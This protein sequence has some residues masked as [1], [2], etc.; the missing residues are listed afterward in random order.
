MEKQK[1]RGIS[2]RAKL[3][4]ITIPIVLVMIIS[5][6]I[7]ASNMVLKIS[8]E[9]LQA[10]SLA[11]TGE[12]SL[13]SNQIFGELEIYKNTINEGNFKDDAAI[14]A[15]METTVDKN[16]SYSVGLYMGDDSGIYLDGSGWVPGDDWVL[17]E[18]D[19]YVDGK[20]NAELAFGEP[21]YD[22]MTGQVC[23]SA[24][25]RMDY[26][27]AVRVLA[28]D[29]Y[30]DYVSGLV[31]DIAKEGVVEAFLVTG[32]SRTIIA[33]P[34]KEMMALTL[35]A[36]D[37]DKMY[38]GIS[39]KIQNGTTGL[40]SVQGAAGEYLVCINPV[41][42]TD[43]YLVTYVTEK[44]VL[45]DLYQMEFYMVLI[46]AAVTVLLIFVILRIMNGVVKPVAKV[47]N[48]IDRI[49]EGDFTQNLEVRGNDE[50]A[51]MSNN[52]Q[53]FIVQMRS[54]ISEISGIAEW[55]DTQ[56]AENAEVSDSLMD[57]SEKQAQAMDVLDK[58]VIQLSVAAESVSRQM[59]QLAEVI[60]FAN[61]EGEA[62]EVLMEESVKMSQG[63]KNDME[64]INAGME[65]I[66]IA[67]TSLS[68]QIGKVG[69]ATAQIGEMVGIIMDIAEE[70]NLLSLNASIEAARAGEAG[71]GFAV[72]A[73]QI[74]KLAA[75]SSVA[76]DDIARLTTEI[77]ST[78]EDAVEHMNTSVKEVENSAD[79]VAGARETFEGLYGKVDETSRRVNQ[80]IE[81]VGMVD[82]VAGELEHITESQV[83]ATEQIV[84][85]AKELDAHMKV[86]AEN[87]NSVAESA[88]ELEQESKKLTE[89]MNKF[90]I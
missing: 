17:T 39:D 35:D 68:E 56:S 41:E 54:T 13:W 12:I 4:G 63:G 23:V 59:E 7:L 75:N 61:E 83:Q 45:S 60:R 64:H 33:H 38:A 18:R 27:K 87:S 19:W 48:V 25:V 85:S 88:E 44:A 84:H 74:G 49:A 26:D 55:L 36:E 81:L 51:R 15:Y 76:A 82:T 65:N 57:A 71:K 1:K 62:A 72:V 30:L 90:R 29:V 34:D 86:L 28:T 70:T 47:T 80:M 77:R 14:L 58:M 22:S 79:I 9:Q 66:T 42:H 6:F 16:E 31:A 53:H 40:V 11:Y 8:K 21:Y 67:I 5:F 10:K 73:E 24:S 3:V 52:I 37:I 89:R 78:V 46:A 43:W 2:I 20:D 69:N 32:N 50:I